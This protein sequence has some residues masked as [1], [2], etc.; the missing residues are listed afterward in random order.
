MD[1]LYHCFNL[2]PRNLC[3][4][5]VYVGNRVAYILELI[6]ADCWRHVVSEDNPVDCASRGMFPSE[7][8]THDL[9][10]SE[11]S[12]LKL[13]SSEWPKNNL[14]SNVT[15]EERVDLE[16][17]PVPWQLLKILSYL[18]TSC[19]LSTNTNESLLGSSDSFITARQE[20]EPLKPRL[21][22]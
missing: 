15:P 21:V 8:L 17:L 12:W 3:R 10:W 11:P 18:S 5:K 1:R 4:F 13:A 20:F 9:W 22:H 6:P 7:L 2:D 14:P 19:H 16:L